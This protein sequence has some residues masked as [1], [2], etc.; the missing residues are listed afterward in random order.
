MRRRIELLEATHAAA[1]EA[2]A[3]RASHPISEMD[4]VTRLAYLLSIEDPGVM[5]FAARA[6]PAF[7]LSRINKTPQIALFD[8]DAREQSR[9][10]EADRVTALIQAEA[11]ADAATRR[12]AESAQAA[13]PVVPSRPARDWFSQFEMKGKPQ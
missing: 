4:L 5:R 13:Q 1:I 3:L 2:A 11:A 8:R 9:Q 7:D 12:A 6:R 10:A